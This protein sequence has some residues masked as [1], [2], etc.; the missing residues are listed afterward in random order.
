MPT[1][2][3]RID[4]LRAELDQHNHLYYVEAKP[5]ISD[6][7][8]DELLKELEAL[9]AEH[10]ELVTADSPTQRVGGTP[11]DGFQTV[12]HA[13]PML[14]IENTYDRD[15]LRGYVRISA[16]RPQDTDRLLDALKD[17]TPS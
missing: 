6:Q 8:F 4:Q 2:Q 13:R 7:A 3:Q 14:S 17:L 1:D 16:G 12:A 5:R 11:I 9:E 15:D 10:P